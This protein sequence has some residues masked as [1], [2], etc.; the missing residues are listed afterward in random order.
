[1]IV[2]DPAHLER[3]NA[4]RGEARR[5][6]CFFHD[7][8]RDFRCSVYGIRPMICRMFGYAGVR[9]KHGAVQFAP[10]PRMENS[11][12]PVVVASVPV[13]QDLQY[14]LMSFAPPEL[15]RLLPFA[16]ALSEAVDRETIRRRLSPEDGSEDR[17]PPSF[18]NA[19]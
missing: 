2:S 11:E 13:F 17:T 9:D 7:G 10:C 18:S 15:A 12:R 1:M 5:K 8:S 3:Y 14:T 6:S 16:E 4:Y 19:A